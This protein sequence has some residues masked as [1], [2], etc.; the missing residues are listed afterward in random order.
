[1]I[2]AEEDEMLHTMEFPINSK[3]NENHRAIVPEHIELMNH[4]ECL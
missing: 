2:R 1:M 4:P 3:E